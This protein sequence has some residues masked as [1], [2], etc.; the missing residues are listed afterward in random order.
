M[1]SSLFVRLVLVHGL[2]AWPWLGMVELMP[3]FN[4]IFMLGGCAAVVTGEIY[5]DKGHTQFLLDVRQYVAFFVSI[6][7]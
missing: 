2:T 5:F 1:H 6:V 7:N 3:G 4:K